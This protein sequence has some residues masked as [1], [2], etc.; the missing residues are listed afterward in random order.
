[1]N[2][3]NRS[4]VALVLCAPSGTG[5]TTLARRLV[6]E[7]PRLSFSLSCTTRA[8]RPGEVEGRD[9]SFINP[10]RFQ[11]MREDDCFAEWAEVH[12]NFY[13]TPLAPTTA[14]LN[15][16]RDVLFD[17][18][19]QGASQLKQTLPNATFAFLLPPSRAILEERLRG[20]GSE[21]EASLARRLANAREEL[22]QANWFDF[23]IINDD[24]EKAYADLCA[25]YAA[26]SLSPA[27]K[28][29]FV[30]NLLREWL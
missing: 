11:Q 3:R 1:M 4:G 27:R 19:V 13:G 14:L 9:Y 25:V 12:G 28:P 5:K 20:R 6:T 16:G 21:S 24:L 29:E 15:E 7:H 26:A 17:I 23:W 8:M 10:E 2:D 22:A 30:N 18:D